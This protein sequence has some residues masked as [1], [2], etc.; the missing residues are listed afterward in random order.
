MGE[1]AMKWQKPNGPADSPCLVH[2]A[3]HARLGL[4]DACRSRAFGVALCITRSM[5]DSVLGGDG[6]DMSDTPYQYV[7]HGVDPTR[8]SAARLYDYYLGGTTNFAVDRAV[9][10]RLKADVPDLIDAVWANRGFH[11]RAAVWLA[12]Q[13]IRQFVDIGSGLPTQNN[14]HEAVH[15]VAPEARV[16]YVDN[17]PMVAAHADALLAEDGTT[18]V[19]T[20]ALPDPGARLGHPRRLALIDL[21]DPAGGL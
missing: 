12:R 1:S 5:P 8:P 18:A 3:E 9:G 2:H 13:G 20:A 7:P 11:G 17:D 14:T 6:G 21:A 19:I 4:A 16:V 10:E 15:R